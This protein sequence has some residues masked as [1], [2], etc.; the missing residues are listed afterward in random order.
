MIAG[1]SEGVCADY[2]DFGSWFGPRGG[3]LGIGGRIGTIGRL[4]LGLGLGLA[5]WLTGEVFNLG[6]D[7]VA[8]DGCYSVNSVLGWGIAPM[9]IC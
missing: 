7:G 6:D 1:D 4:G 2:G 9:I 8:L 3:R 5:S